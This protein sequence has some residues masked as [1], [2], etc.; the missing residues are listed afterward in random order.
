MQYMEE[1]S[2]YEIDPQTAFPSLSELPQPP[3]LLRVRGSIPSCTGKKCIAIVGSRAYTS[4]GA[5][6]CRSLI[7]GLKDYPVII[8]SGLA[9]GIDAIAHQSALEY[10][11]PT[12]AFPGSGLDWNV[13]YPK[14]HKELARDILR[15]G[16]ALISEYGNDFRATPWS[17]PQRNRLV[18]GIADMVIVIEAKEKSGALITARL[19]T[20]YSKSVGAVPGSVFSDASSGTNWLLHMGA[21]VIRNT[22]DIVR[23]LGLAPQ[24]HSNNQTVTNTIEQQILTYLSEPRTKDDIIK[25]L[26]LSPIEANIVFS[27]LEIKGLIKETYGMIERIA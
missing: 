24:T 7:R 27:T 15:H 17:F 20:E 22:D 9:L 13:L 5:E 19:G 3:S 25:T 8:V 4:Y 6:V 11:I 14:M 10:N 1:F 16:G 21:V 12:I 26:A 2:I 18:A 23:E